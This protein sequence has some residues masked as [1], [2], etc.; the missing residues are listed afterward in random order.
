MQAEGSYEGVLTSMWAF[1]EARG[2][3]WK[4]AE[5]PKPHLELCSLSVVPPITCSFFFIFSFIYLK[6]LYSACQRHIHE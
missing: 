2:E 6:N 1:K 4:V 5:T 3:K